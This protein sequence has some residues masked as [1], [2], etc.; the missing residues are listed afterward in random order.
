M[1]SRLGWAAA[2]VASAVSARAEVSVRVANRTAHTEG[3]WVAVFRANATTLAKKEHIDR[4]RAIADKDPVSKIHR[5]FSIN[6]FEGYAARFSDE[7]LRLATKDDA[8]LEYIEVDGLVSIDAPVPNREHIA[9]PHAVKASLSSVPEA[10]ANGTAKAASCN[11]QTN[12]VWGLTRISERERKMHGK[13]V[14]DRT[15]TNVDAY[16][17]DTGIYVDH[18]DFQGRAEWGVSFVGESTDSN[19][20]GTHCAGTIGGFVYGVAKDVRLVAVQVLSG[21]GSGS[22]SGVIAGLEWVCQEHKS[23]KNDGKKCVINLSLSGG[24]YDAM[25]SAANYAAKCGCAVV[26]AAGN[27]GADACTQSPAAAESV[28]TVGAISSGDS[29]P[30]FS[31]Y[32]S[33]VDIFAPG[34][35]IKSTWIGSSKAANAISGTSMAAPHVAGAAALLLGSG[36]SNADSIKDDLMSTASTGYLSNLGSGSPNLLLYNGGNC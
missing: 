32:G 15:G 26:A 3:H 24:R 22:M 29:K 19:G 18:E 33:C 30:Y 34:V 14:Y 12:A 25:D 17:L 5:T 28:I 27:D 13:Y 23:R 10:A 9:V 31:N 11:T 1:V 7:H 36:F 20:H 8:V 21:S 6:G 2:V 4:H 16:I 35:Y